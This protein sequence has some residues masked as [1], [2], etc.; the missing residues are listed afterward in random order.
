[1]SARRCASSNV[2]GESCR[3]A[4]LAD[5]E[6]CRMHD[7]GSAEEVAECRRLGGLHR[8]RVR[9]VL[10]AHEIEGVETV[11]QVQALLVANIV[12]M[13]QLPPGVQRSQALTR[14]AEVALKAIEHHQVDERL[15]NLE[16]A[17]FPRR[18]QE[19]RR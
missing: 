10:G 1:M 19:S 4:P 18:R 12:D 5:G 9:L 2:A 3:A 17:V 7:P 11:E 13:L 15:V 8:R 6:Y 14:A 16:A